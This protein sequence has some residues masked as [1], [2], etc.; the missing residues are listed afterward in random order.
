MT[1]VMNYS[2]SS[3]RSNYAH[4]IYDIE[5]ITFD[6]DSFVAQVEADS[7]EEAHAKAAA[8]F[9]DIDYTCL[10]GFYADW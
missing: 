10:I 5:A 4:G 8:Q 2:A 1:A 3:L 7:E 9:D 6:G